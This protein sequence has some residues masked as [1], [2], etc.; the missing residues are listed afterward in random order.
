MTTGSK[1]KVLHFSLKDI[2]I[3]AMMNDLVKERFPEL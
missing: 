3:I 2:Y 1:E